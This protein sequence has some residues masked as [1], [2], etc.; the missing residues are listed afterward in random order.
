MVEPPSGYKDFLRQKRQ[1]ALDLGVPTVIVGALVA[2]LAA[3]V[4]GQLPVL[5]PTLQGCA[6]FLVLA[7]LSVFAG[8]QIDSRR[9][10]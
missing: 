4:N 8:K 9:V 3:L 6:A 7:L 1:Q 5:I 2:T 10:Q